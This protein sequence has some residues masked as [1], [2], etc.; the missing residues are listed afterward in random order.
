[1][2]TPTQNYEFQ[3]EAKL[4]GETTALKL[5][6][7]RAKLS[8]AA[9]EIY[10]LRKALS[11]PKTD[12]GGGEAPK[13]ERGIGGAPKLSGR[14]PLGITDGQTGKE[15]GGRS[16]GA[17]R[18]PVSA[19]LH[20]TDEGKKRP[21]PATSGLGARGIGGALGVVRGDPSG[22]MVVIFFFCFLFLRGILRLQSCRS[23]SCDRGLY[24]DRLWR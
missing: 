7:V 6:K 21:R 23:L 2:P 10:S 12:Q 3:R 19:L 5:D 18:T 8:R 16:R 22:E 1:M 15:G 14:S 13:N 4:E 17:S 20:R 24:C 9:K 11:Q